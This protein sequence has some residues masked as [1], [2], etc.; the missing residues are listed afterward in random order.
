VLRSSGLDL[1]FKCF[2]KQQGVT[3]AAI[4]ENKRLGAALELIRKKQN[5]RD[6][7]R[8]ENPKMTTREKRRLQRSMRL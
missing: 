6:L 8:L 4:V 5:E 3:Q 1:P 2:D 7:V